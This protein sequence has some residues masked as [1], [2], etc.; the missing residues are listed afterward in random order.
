MSMVPSLLSLQPMTKVVSEESAKVYPTEYAWGLKG[1]VQN[2][3]RGRANAA[4]VGLDLSKP[5]S[6]LDRR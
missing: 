1:S 5:R 3:P 2:T 4:I 6:S